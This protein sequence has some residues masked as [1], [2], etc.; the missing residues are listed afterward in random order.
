MIAPK[1]TDN[2]C[3][4]RACGEYFSCADTFDRHR[5]GQFGI[6]R[7]CMTAAE[8]D[9][10]GFARNRRG[11]RMKPDRRRGG[12]DLPARRAP[13]AMVLPTPAPDTAGTRADTLP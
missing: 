5:I 8:M 2:R 3:Q 12:A 9:A 6:D 1:L 11:F 4:C 10:A 7:R 13:V